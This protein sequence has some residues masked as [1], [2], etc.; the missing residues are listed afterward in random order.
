MTKVSARRRAGATPSAYMPV[1]QGRV[2]QVQEQ[3]FRLVRD[4]QSTYLLTLAH[5]APIDGAELNGFMRSGAPVVVEYTGE[6]G[7]ASGVAHGVRPA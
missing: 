2:T 7:L 3:R 4:D 5:D 1:V 6:P